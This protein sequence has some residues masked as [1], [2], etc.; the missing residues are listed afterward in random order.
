MDDATAVIFRAEKGALEQKMQRSGGLDLS[1]VPLQVDESFRIS[2]K[3]L[4]KANGYLAR[5]EEVNKKLALPEFPQP[6]CRYLPGVA[7][8][9]L[10]YHSSHGKGGIGA[11]G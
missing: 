1:K 3:R 5:I 9:T 4:Q 7:G 8:I 10:H 6:G 2:M 11:I